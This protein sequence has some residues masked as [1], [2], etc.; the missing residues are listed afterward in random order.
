LQGINNNCFKLLT[1]GYKVEVTAEAVYCK[2]DDKLKLELPKVK[3][4]QNAK[5]FYV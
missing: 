4:Y 1:L 3:S 5:Y 2:S